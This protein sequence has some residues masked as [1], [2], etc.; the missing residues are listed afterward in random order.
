MFAIS[1]HWQCH[2][3]NGSPEIHRALCVSSSKCIFHCADCFFFVFCVELQQRRVCKKWSE[4]QGWSYVW[5]FVASIAYFHTTGSVRFVDDVFILR[6]DMILNRKRARCRTN[7]AGWKTWDKCIKLQ[8]KSCFALYRQQFVMPYIR[9]SFDIANRCR[10]NAR[11][12]LCRNSMHL[13]HFVIVDI[14][15]AET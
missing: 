13:S 5:R 8:H 2:H 6:Y 3:V 4:R 10:Y 11:K 7:L 15:G 9:R 1:Y 14:Y 12:L